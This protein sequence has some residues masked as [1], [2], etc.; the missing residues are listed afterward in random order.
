VSI[1]RVVFSPDAARQFRNL[2]ATERSRLKDG[3]RASLAEDD[4]AVVSANRF[5]LRRPSEFADFEF[6]L[7]DLRLFY[8]VVEN[9]VR[10]VLIGRKKGNQLFIDGKRFTL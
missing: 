4:A 10:V 1:R 7:G 8:R 6:R 3:I 5:P 2:R 9:E